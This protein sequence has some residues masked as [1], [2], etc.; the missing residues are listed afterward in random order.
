MGVPQRRCSN[1]GESYGEGVIFCPRDGTALPARSI[2]SGPDAYLGRTVRGEFRIDAL[3]GAGAVARVYR[4]HQLGVERS[5]ALKI[6]HRDLASN[7]GMRARFQREARIA[8]SLCHPNLVNVLSLGEL[9]QDGQTI[10]FLAFEY[11]DGLT[12]RSILLAQGALPPARAVHILLQ[13]ASALGEAHSHGIVHRDLKPENTMLVRRG[14]DSDFVKVLDFGVARAEARSDAEIDHRE[15]A[16][17]AGAIFGSARYVAP[18]CAA[19][20]SST[21]AS[22]VY[23]LAI[24]GYECLSGSPPFEGENAVQV[25]LKQQTAQVPSLRERAP[26][27]PPALA[28]LIQQNLAKSPQDRCSDARELARALLAAADETLPLTKTRFGHALAATNSSPSAAP[29]ESMTPARVERSSSARAAS[30]ALI[31]LLC[32]LLGIS[33]AL[34]IAHQLGAFASPTKAGPP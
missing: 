1:C 24:L 20:G 5:V 4:A 34:G 33:A 14:D 23:A 18:E 17:R 25:L 7:D 13:I 16:T 22:D 2:D 11:L 3:I 21:P 12:L 8:G 32:F 15:I 29:A 19:G 31:I 27:T 26:H 30:P 28:N 10:P 6:M 9:E